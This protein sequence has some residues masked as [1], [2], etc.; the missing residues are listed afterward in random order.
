MSNVSLQERLAVQQHQVLAA[1]S[2]VICAACTTPPA[3]Y[4][5]DGKDAAGQ[6]DA[7]ALMA[8]NASAS[9]AKRFP[10]ASSPPKLLNAV[11]P[12]ISRAAT[13]HGGMGTVTVEVL[14]STTGHVSLV[15]VLES[16]SQY[17]SDDVSMAVRQWVFTPLMVDG[18]AKEFQFRYPFHFRLGA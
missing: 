8:E 1:L 14:V 5:V 15:T 6:K 11:A 3:P 16:P 10:N 2:L 9:L 17:L 12:V 18:E 4:N 7:S 13:N